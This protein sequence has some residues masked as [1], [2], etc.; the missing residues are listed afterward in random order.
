MIKYHYWVTYAYQCK[1]GNGVGAR[2]LSTLSLLNSAEDVVE[3][4]DWII[5]NDADSVKNNWDNLIINGFY[6]LRRELILREWLRTMWRRTATFLKF[7][8]K[9]LE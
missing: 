6:L 1:T 5:A 7:I 2:P 8:W 9:I 3:V 4:R